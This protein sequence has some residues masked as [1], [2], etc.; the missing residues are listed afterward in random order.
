[1]FGPDSRAEIDMLAHIADDEAAEISGR[2]DRLAVSKTSVLIADFKTGKPP[3]TGQNAPANYIRQLAIYKRVLARIYPNR[4]MRALLV[5]TE[6]STIQEIAPE[7]LE[8]ALRSPH[9]S[10]TST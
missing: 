2:I 4:A 9:A 6:T 7:H 10:V 3:N 1:L 5:W 8:A